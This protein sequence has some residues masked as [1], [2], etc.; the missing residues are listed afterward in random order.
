VIA[1]LRPVS[2]LLTHQHG[3]AMPMV[4]VMMMVFSVGIVS[5]VMYTSS[6]QSAT[7]AQKKG[8]YAHA[9]AEAALATAISV[10]GQSTDPTVS[11]LLPQCTGT[12]PGQ[13]LS[14]QTPRADGYFCGQLVGSDWTITATGVARG[15]STDTAQISKKTITQVATICPFY[16]GG[17]GPLWDRIYQYDASKCTEFKKII[18]TVPVV[19][20]GC[21]KLDGDNAHPSRVVGASV[22]VGG[23]VT[24]KDQDSIGLSSARI[25][26][27]DIAGT[28]TIE[29][30]SGAHFPCG[31]A[32]GVYAASPG[33]G[34]T[35]DFTRPT[36]NYATAY[37]SAKPGPMQACTY[38]SGTP[39]AIKFDKNFSFNKDNDPQ[40]LTPNGVSYDCEVWSTPPRS[41]TMLGQIAW[42]AVEQVLTVN[43]A[44]FFDG[45]AKI[46]APGHSKACA[47]AD[48]GPYCDKSFSYNGRG[49]IYTSKKFDLEAG[50]CSGGD[51]S[52]DCETDPT[53]WDPRTNLLIIISGG[54]LNP[55]DEAFK[56]DKDEAVFQGAVYSNGRCKI[57]KKASVS[58]PLICGQLGIKEDDSLD[59]PTLNP[60]PASLIG[61]RTGQVWPTPVNEYQIMLQPQL[62]G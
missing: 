19:T 31:D 50:L 25:P 5:V 61:Q 12:P 53:N 35:P 28:C 2:A 39:T 6:S 16:C 48:H 22:S 17:L 47:K 10:L 59:D 1:R 30:G 13:A 57:N 43:G 46:T 41:G 23:N 36:I 52:N 32:D 26:R 24:L 38:T 29:H 21:L 7:D 44:V 14:P 54:L 20:R 33:V 34:T 8:A 9:A 60:W 18:V 37:A 56:M 11:T 42:D 15:T 55:G 51:G 3:F 45:E 4:I 27:A 58:A 40:Q 49:V 62:G